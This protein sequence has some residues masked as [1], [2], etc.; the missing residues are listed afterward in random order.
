[1]ETIKKLH[2]QTIDVGNKNTYVKYSEDLPDGALTVEQS[3]PQK[4]KYKL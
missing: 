1:M 3:N 4:L 2:N